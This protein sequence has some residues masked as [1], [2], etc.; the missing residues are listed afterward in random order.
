MGC[1]ARS[2]ASAR[3]G[4]SRAQL[5]DVVRVLHE[6]H[7]EHEVGLERDAVLEPEGDE[8]D[9]QLVG[10]G[11]GGD[12]GEQPLAELAQREIGRV[13]DDVGLG[14]DRLEAPA[15]VGDA[16]AMPR[17]SASGWRWRVSL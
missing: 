7:V 11:Q 2:R 6:P 3:S 17:P 4:R 1:R 15:L 13:Q 12:L 14:P 8:L 9:G 16:W 5:R 10:P